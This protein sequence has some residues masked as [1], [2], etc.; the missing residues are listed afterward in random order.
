MFVNIHQL[1]RFWRNSMNLLP[2]W[3]SRHE[4]AIHFSKTFSSL[5][6]TVFTILVI[7][8][9]FLNNLFVLPS[10]VVCLFIRFFHSPLIIN[11]SNMNRDSMQLV[12][13]IFDT[14]CF[15]STLQNCVTNRIKRN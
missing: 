6:G 3:Y 11:F 8:S 7:S 13:C 5:I 2:H 15:S 1:T 9:S 10:V 12:R 4:R 14:I